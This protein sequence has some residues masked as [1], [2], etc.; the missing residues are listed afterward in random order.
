MGYVATWTRY[1]PYISGMT[2][3]IW[4]WEK[5]L[6]MSSKGMR[7]YLYMVHTL[8]LLTIGEHTSLPASHS[9][10]HSH[11]LSLSWSLSLVVMV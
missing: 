6:Q 11:S 2:V 7:V 4:R 3:A 1:S 8:V 9:L 5:N 10:T